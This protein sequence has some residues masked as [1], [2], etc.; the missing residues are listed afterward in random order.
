M[1]RFDPHYYRV[2]VVA[3]V[4]VWDSKCIRFHRVALSQHHS[5]LNRLP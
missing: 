3:R 1:R 5:A 4:N 2:G